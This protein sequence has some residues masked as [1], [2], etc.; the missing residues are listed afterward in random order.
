MMGRVAGRLAGDRDLGFAF[1]DLY[2]RVK[3]SRVLAQALA[4]LESEQ[5]DVAAVAFDQRPADH[6]AFLV[7]DQIGQQQALRRR[8]RFGFDMLWIEPQ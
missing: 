3:R 2:Q 7:S 5:G 4:F 1:E 6:G 8:H